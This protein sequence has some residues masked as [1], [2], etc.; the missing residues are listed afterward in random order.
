TFKY[1]FLPRSWSGSL[2]AVIERRLPLIY[3]LK[4]H[5][6]RSVVNWAIKQQVELEGSIRQTRENELNEERRRNERFE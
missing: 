4:E 5:Q 6:D 2:A 3:E 1:S